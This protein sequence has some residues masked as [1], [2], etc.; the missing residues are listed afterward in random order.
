MFVPEAL[1]RAVLAGLTLLVGALTLGPAAWPRAEAPTVTRTELPPVTAA[2]ESG[3]PPTYPTTAS[4]TPL[5]S[6]RLDLNT[7]SAEQL[8]ALPGIGPALAGRMIAGRPYRSL[9][10]LDAVKGIGEATLR[11]LTPLVRW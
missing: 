2:P 10:D 8:E 5:I 9:A 3:G 7:A 11:R 6:G 1:W 4:V